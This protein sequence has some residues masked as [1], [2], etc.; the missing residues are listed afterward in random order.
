M[1]L[2]DF[3]TNKEVR[4]KIIKD[5]FGLREEEFPERVVVTPIPFDFQFP[6]NFESSLAGLGVRVTRVKVTEDWTLRDYGKTYS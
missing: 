1:A 6:K 2:G 5:N 4:E 3:I